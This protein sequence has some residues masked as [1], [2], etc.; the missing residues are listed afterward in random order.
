MLAL[1]NQQREAASN[2]KTNGQ[3]I[4]SFFIAK[5]ISRDRHTYHFSA[6]LS[7]GKIVPMRNILFC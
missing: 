5:R 2:K 3:Q 1:Q 6:D 4:V 7:C